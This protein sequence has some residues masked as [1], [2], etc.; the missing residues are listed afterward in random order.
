MLH[1]IRNLPF[2]GYSLRSIVEEVRHEHFPDQRLPVGV[3]FVSA[4]S[5]ASIH[6]ESDAATIYIHQ[7]LNHPE[8]PREVFTMI[9]KHEL[10]HLRFP[11]LESIKECTSHPPEFWK[12]EAAISPERQKAWRWIHQN[13]RHSI[14][15]R[16]KKERVDVL[17]NWKQTWNQVRDP[18]EGTLIRTNEDSCPFSAFGEL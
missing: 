13:L 1:R 10:L 12:A 15:V 8:T 9:V 11:V 3:F 16:R 5:L 6:T 17:R 2:S 4:G 18:M 14:R 7:L